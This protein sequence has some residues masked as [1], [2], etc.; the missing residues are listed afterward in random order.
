MRRMAFIGSAFGYGA[1]NYS[2]SLGPKYIKV[3]YDLV[4]KL[5]DLFIES[6]WYDIVET[7]EINLNFIP[8]TG[9]NYK[10]VL[11]HSH[12]LNLS[13]KQFLTNA[14]SDFPVI[15]G[16]DHSCA[17]GL[18]S[19]I[20]DTLN[21]NKKYGLIWID[22]H[23]D[24]HTLDTSPSKAYHGRPLSFLLGYNTEN[25]QLSHVQVSPNNLVI[26]GARSFEE[27]EEKILNLLRVRIFYID[28]VHKRGLKT[29]FEE[30]VS[31][32]NRNTKSF[33]VSLDLDSIDPNDAPGVGSPVQ[34]GL[35]WLELKNNLPIVFSNPNFSALEIAEFNPK[36]DV[37]NKT[38][39]IIF[40]VVG[41]LGGCLFKH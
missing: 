35:S 10:A 19:G 8:N 28:E 11:Q 9:K 20:I 40:Q 14:N 21:A 5:K 23:M 18:W 13:I 36:L 4:K 30:A 39:E 24:A 7:N 37:E 15:I 17:I 27:E 38:A 1:Q 6:Y 32:V 33:G 22:A 41:I 26:I 29:V 3:G 16:G 12:K 25:F 2:T 34:N 31:I